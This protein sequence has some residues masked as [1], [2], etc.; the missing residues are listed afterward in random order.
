MRNVK[1]VNIY[2]GGKML[3]VVDTMSGSFSSGF[4]LLLK[5]N[6]AVIG[7]RFPLGS[8]L[9]A[10]A[11]NVPYQNYGSNYSKAEL[12]VSLH[13]GTNQWDL[14]RISLSD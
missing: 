2:K 13:L 6:R 11:S 1:G 12:N 10:C 8:Y 14:C 9:S 7:F 3:F 5:E 4:N